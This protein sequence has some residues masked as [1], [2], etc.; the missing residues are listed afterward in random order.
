[1]PLT[2]RPQQVESLRAASGN[3]KSVVR[4]PNRTDWVEIRLVD[5][6]N[7][8]VAGA[9]YRL[10]LPDGSV[11]EGQLDAQGWASADGIAPG[12]CQVS[13]PEYDQDCW[14]REGK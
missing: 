14:V 12:D 3:G 8:G 2:I 13:F 1:M 9:K 4:C 7:R 11:K 5:A 6:E 10:K